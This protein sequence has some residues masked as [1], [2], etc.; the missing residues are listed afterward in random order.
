MQKH[1][2]MLLL[3]LA[4]ATLS[5]GTNVWTSHGPGGGVV[6]SLVIDPNHSATVYASTTGG[7]FKSTDNGASWNL[8]NAG[9]ALGFVYSLGIDPSAPRLNRAPAVVDTSSS[10]PVRER[11]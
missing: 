5:A 11:P 2:I 10:D 8:A 7:V 4:P 1:A 3:L 9:L 6:Q